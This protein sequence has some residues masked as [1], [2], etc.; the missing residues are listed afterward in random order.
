MGG[1]PAPQAIASSLRPTEAQMNMGHRGANIAR[2]STI[3]SEVAF[4]QG[5]VVT[6]W[7]FESNASERSQK[8]AIT[9]SMR[10]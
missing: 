3:F 2:N 5:K 1:L 4:G 7:N 9:Q 8:T 6:G 10:A